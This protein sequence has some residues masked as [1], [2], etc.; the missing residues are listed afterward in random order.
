MGAT[1]S[2]CSCEDD[3]PNGADDAKRPGRETR[4]R[5]ASEFTIII[6]RRSGEGLGI[7]A[8]PEKNGTLEL[9][10]ITPGG[11][12]DRW[13][14]SQPPGSQELVKPGMRVV[15]VNGRYSSAVQLIA[16][17]REAEVLHITM[18]P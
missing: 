11:L 1:G 7:D 15:E 10:G 16:A 13:N 14:C 18:M 17:C 4:K 8:A 3:L 9:K 2:C 12:V 6:D 5:S